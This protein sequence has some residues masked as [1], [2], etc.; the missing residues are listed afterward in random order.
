MLHEEAADQIMLIAETARPCGRRRQEQARIL[1]A[2]T[3]EHH[4]A[5]PDVGRLPLQ[6]PQ[7]DA[8]DGTLLPGNLNP[9]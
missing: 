3:G 7:L 1:Q 5:R 8:F 4:A 9:L 6:R 2:T